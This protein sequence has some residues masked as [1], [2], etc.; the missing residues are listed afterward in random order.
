MREG[1]TQQ[2]VMNG[3]W[4]TCNAVRLH[5]RS[6]MYALLLVEG[7]FFD[8]GGVLDKVTDHSLLVKTPRDIDPRTFKPCHLPHGKV[9]VGISSGWKALPI[10]R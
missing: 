2:Q 3:A 8:V 7:V 10:V 9:S 1:G 5:C 6:C 4:M